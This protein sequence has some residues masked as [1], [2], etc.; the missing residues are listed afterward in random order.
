MVQAHS[1]RSPRRGVCVGLVLMLFA[2]LANVG[3]ITGALAGVGRNDLV[4]I[5]DAVQKGELLPLPRIMEL[6]LAR[7]PG[8]VVKTELESERGR[9]IYEIKILTPQG[10]VREVKLDARTGSILLVE[11][12]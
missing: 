8:D 6:A 4:A 5:R 11:D 10:S 2:V 1:P 12:D 9:L 3:L 7:V